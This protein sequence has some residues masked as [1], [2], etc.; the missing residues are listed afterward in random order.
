VPT[1]AL[2]A[3]RDEFFVFV[4]RAD[5][6]FVQTK[7]LRGEQH[8]AHTTVLDGVHPGDSLVTEGAVL[9]DVALNEAF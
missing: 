3:R 9:L 6:A 2:I 8:G 4:K 1:S 5:G 7:V